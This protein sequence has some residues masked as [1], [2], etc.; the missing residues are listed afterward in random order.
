MAK[1]EPPAEH[2]RRMMEGNGVWILAPS[3]HILRR[4]L[5]S[6]MQRLKIKCLHINKQAVSDWLYSLFFFRFLH[7]KNVRKKNL[8]MRTSRTMEFRS[9]KKNKNKCKNGKMEMEMEWKMELGNPLVNV[10]CMNRWAPRVKFMHICWQHLSGKGLRA[11]THS[12]R[13]QLECFYSLWFT[14]FSLKRFSPKSL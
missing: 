8:K 5:S 9:K 1:D 11:R 6:R 10:K 2:G 3:W 7:S 14:E 12:N 4:Q 13:T